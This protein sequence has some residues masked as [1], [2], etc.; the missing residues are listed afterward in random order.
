MEHD[1]KRKI[2]RLLDFL[3]DEKFLRYIYVLISEM[4]TKEQG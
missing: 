2:I 3:D 1:Y 4:V